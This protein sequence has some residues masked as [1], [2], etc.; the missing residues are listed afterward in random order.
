MRNGDR[1]E[2]RYL[3][4][5]SFLKDLKEGELKPILDFEKNY[6]DSFLIEIRK[7]YLDLYFLG[8]AIKVERTNS[9]YNL[10]S[11]Q[12][13]RPDRV[14]KW[15][16]SF[17]DI[18]EKYKDYE[19]NKYK[20]E[21]E[22]FM[23]EIMFKIIRH[24]KGDISEGVSEMNHYIDNRII[25]KPGDIVVIDRQVTHG[26]A[27]IDLLGLK[28]M[29]NG[30]LSF[31]VFELKNK[32]NK[33]IEEVFSQIKEYIDILWEHY[34]E[35]QQTYK[36]V[37]EQKIKLGLLDRRNRKEIAD[38]PLSKQEIEGIIVLDNYNLRSIRLKSALEKDWANIHDS[39]NIKLFLK[40]NTFDDNFF[41][42]YEEARKKNIWNL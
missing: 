14:G 16:I 23:S 12:V 25:Y 1:I 7:N 30:K 37:L 13:F 34:E 39:Y 10:S 35:F 21:F 28:K 17:H 20:S 26:R 8:H 15:P 33:D 4:E 3:E 9:D 29:N 41:W 5:D 2:F 11:A 36:Q 19:K 40:T 24:K 38:K 18:K 27:R 6:R 22:E 32:E 31:V 42:N